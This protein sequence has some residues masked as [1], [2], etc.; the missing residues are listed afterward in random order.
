MMFPGVNSGQGKAKLEKV[1]SKTKKDQTLVRANKALNNV[2]KITDCVGDDEPNTATKISAIRAGKEMVS[3]TTTNGKCVTAT[4]SEAGPIDELAV[5]HKSGADIKNNTIKINND[6]TL[7]VKNTGGSVK[8]S[9]TETAVGYRISAYQP[10]YT[11]TL[12]ASGNYYLLPVLTENKVMTAQAKEDNKQMPIKMEYINGYKRQKWSI[13]LI[14]DKDI[15]TGYVAG[16]SN[17][18]EYKILE[19]ARFRSL[20]IQDDDNKENNAVIAANEFNSKARNDTE[21]WKITPIGN[22]TYTIKT[23]RP[24]FK[25]GVNTGNIYPKFGSDKNEVLIGR[26]N[27]ETQRFK[28]ISIDY[29]SA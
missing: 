14:T 1:V 13:E 20:S 27:N 7:I 2:S 5:W 29:S 15:S 4:L 25:N 9:E 6:D 11:K 26:I 8:T 17:T 10:N 28:L 22:G 21:I 24:I 12:P 16:N 19:L 23:V 3:G 18:Y